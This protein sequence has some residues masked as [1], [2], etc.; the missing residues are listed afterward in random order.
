[1]KLVKTL[2]GIPVTNAQEVSATAVDETV[3]TD[4]TIPCDTVAEGPGEYWYRSK[5][6]P[7]MSQWG[8]MPLEINGN[9]CG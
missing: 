3:E 2:A 4:V 7:N 9:R 8:M 1:M 5:Y 6:K